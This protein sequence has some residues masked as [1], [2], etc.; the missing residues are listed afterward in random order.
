MSSTPVRRTGPSSR[1]TEV[2]SAAASQAGDGA[3][4][5]AWR[6]E[7]SYAN[8]IARAFP[9]VRVEADTLAL[10]GIVLFSLIIRL[11]MLG[12]RPLHHDESLH[13]T[14]SYYLM[15]SL[16]PKYYYDPM[17]HGPLQFHMMAFFYSIF[18]SSPFSARLWSVTAGT[19]LVAVPWLLRRQLG[20]W[21]MFALMAILSLSPIALYFSRF[22]REDMQFALFTFLMVASLL[23]YITDRQD[24]SSYHYRWLLVFGLSTGMAYAAKESIFL[25]VAMLGGFLVVQISRELLRGPWLAGPVLGVAMI[26]AGIAS[27]N[28][29]ISVVGALF[30]LV[31]MVFQIWESNRTG[32]VTEAVRST[33]LWAWLLA[34]GTIVVLFVLLYWPIGYPASWAFVPGSHMQATTL[35][36]PGQAKPK[37]F[38]YSTDGLTG[39]LLYWQAQQPVARGGQPWFYYLFVI[40]LYEW[41][42]VLFGIV[43]AVYIAL[44]RRNLSTMLILWWTGASF[45]IYGWTSEK[46]P[47]N[48][49]HLVVPLAVLAAIGLVVSIVHTRRWLR[50][51][52]IAAAVITGVISTHN[53]VT[54]AYVNGANPV[55]YMVYVQTT[56]DVPRVFSEMERIQSHLA[57]PLHIQVDNGDTWPWAFYL[58]DNKKFAIDTYPSNAAGFGTPTQPVLL[59]GTEDGAY[60][61]LKTTLAGRYVAFKEALRWWNPEEY[62]PAYVD[63]LNS[64]GQPTSALQRFG[65]F[66]KDAVTPS[67]WSNIMQWEIGR[68]PFSPHA[69]DNSGNQVT[70]WF[71]VK[72]D[73]ISYLSPALQAQAQAQLQAAALQNPF[74]SKMRPLVPRTTYAAGAAA[75]SSVGPVASDAHGNV[76]VG[77]LSRQRIVELSPTGAVLRSW[78]SAGTGP[79][80]F[81]GKFSPSIG[82]IAVAPNGNVYVTDTWNGRVQEFTPTGAFIRAWGKQNLAQ[83]HLKV[84]DFYGPRGI[85]VGTTGWVYVADTGHKR[86]QVFDLNGKFLR[87]IGR[88]GTGL[89]QFNEPSSV[90]VDPTGRLFVADYWNSR[91]QVFNVM[92]QAQL[93]FNVMAWQSGSYD[94]PQIAVDA[95]GRV[96]VPDPAGARMLV[97]SPSGKPLYAWGGVGTANGQFTKPVGAVAGS[98]GT[99]LISDPGNSRIQAF[100]A[101]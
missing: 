87:S 38:N 101:P 85:A 100:T 59:V 56:P 31:I 18:G 21:P 43:G 75:F 5:L 64:Q 2:V 36:I 45:L 17:M 61:A 28:L 24:G 68:K 71:L 39:G 51:V 74:S 15:G 22:A 62:K 81:N 19:A 77:D 34:G 46:M 33:P 9:M 91:I 16:D 79:G 70:F 3:T 83:D 50:Y 72:K 67:T 40:P 6:A 26:F 27:H 7:R 42:V 29:K 97:Y 44:K 84:D 95:T 13:A 96:F 37:P 25:T 23:R 69:W 65:Y 47:W 80:Q 11:V 88:S 10:A 32:P 55:E 76:Y 14:Y 4:S 89:G 8:P 99:I 52:A 60:D 58:R 86:V 82:G 35:D 63:R 30:I 93:S 20:R 92:G 48:A 53:A 90:A 66:L 1:S 41:L 12:D 78:G 98:G 54:L 57:T 94:E 49:L 73:Y